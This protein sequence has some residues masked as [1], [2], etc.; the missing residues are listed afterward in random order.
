[1]RDELEPDLWRGVSGISVLVMI[2]A[3]GAALFL[4]ASLIATIKSE[5]VQQRWAATVGTRDTVLA[6]YPAQP[7]NDSAL[8]LTGLTLPI[9]IDI[10]PR[11]DRERERPVHELTVAQR[12]DVG[13]YLD[14]LESTERTLQPPSP[15]LTSF[16]EQHRGHIDAV[17]AHLLRHGKPEWEADLSKLFAA[18]IPNLLGHLDLQKLMLA[19][20]LAR[21]YAGDRTGALDGL[22]ASWELNRGLRDDPVLISQLIAMA[23]HRMQLGALRQL[24]DVPDSWSD[25]L[26]E[27]DFRASFHDA[28]ELE[29]WVWTQIDDVESLAGDGIFQRALFKV[30][31][32]YVSYCLADVSDE[33]RERLG[34]LAKVDALCDADLSALGADLD[35]PPPRWNVIGA[36]IVPS[37][38][39]AVDRLR[40]LEL[41]VELTERLLELDAERRANDGEW[42]ARRASVELSTV[43][44]DD[45]WS[46][47]TAEDGSMTIA[48]SREISWPD[49][50]GTILPTE[51]KLSGTDLS[52]P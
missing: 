29:G 6:R 11:W 16:L 27:H 22:A 44:P 38:R 17:H 4:T 9:G 39:G 36:M 34:N 43:C 10:A 7:A 32:P 52:S 30:A 45:R 31:R 37:L 12:H 26:D 46:Y 2:V 47:T 23:A 18:P 51:F 1:M 13:V 14:H 25:R 28:L 48:F 41:D 50:V 35:I 24:R 40:R 49:Q 33:Y 15:A 8:T 3:I 21:N 5:M 20:V 19:D 42:P